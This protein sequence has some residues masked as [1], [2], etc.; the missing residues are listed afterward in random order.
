MV[1]YDTGTGISG[2]LTGAQAGFAMGGPVGGAIGGAIGLTT[3]FFGN[4]KKKKKPHSTLDKNQQ[5]IYNDYIASLRGEGP[6]ADLFNFDANQYNN[7]FD[8]TI[9]RQAY[10][11]F[12][13]NI[14]PSITGQ[15]RGGN[16]MNSSYA[17]E[18]LSRAGRDIQENLD[19]LRSQNVFQGQQQANQNR[20]NATQN[21]LNLQTQAFERPEGS[22]I[23]KILSQVGP[24]ASELFADYI[25]KKNSSDAATPAASPSGPF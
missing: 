1:K 12:N 3:G 14:I 10:R 4:K 21:L 25:K 19:A 15:F 2:G 8:Q 22:T 18:S 24:Q 17:G 11:N 13:E 6:N 16:L 5:Q 20:M 23:D 9:G 7:V